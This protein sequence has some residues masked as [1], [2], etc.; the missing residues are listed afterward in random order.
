M[1]KILIG[2]NPFGRY[3]AKSLI[4]KVDEIHVYEPYYKSNVKKMRRENTGNLVDVSLNELNYIKDLAVHSNSPRIII[5]TIPDDH[6]VIMELVNILAEDDCI[7]NM[8][9][10][11]YKHVTEA[12]DTCLQ[13][14]IN[15]LDCAVFDPRNGSPPRLLVSGHQTTYSSYEHFFKEC[16]DNF[17]Y[18]DQKAGKATHVNEVYL[19]VETAMLQA[20]EDISTY[21]NHDMNFMYNVTCEL[22]KNYPI[23]NKLIAE[24]ADLY[25]TR[26]LRELKRLRLEI[27]NEGKGLVSCA[28][29]AFKSIPRAT[30]ISA[31]VANQLE[32]LDP[33]ECLKVDDNKCNVQRAC[34]A[35]LFVFC[36]ILLEADAL[37][38]VESVDVP[39]AKLSLQESVIDCDTFR[40]NNERL[41]ELTDM[42]HLSAELI[43]TKCMQNGYNIPTLSAAVQKYNKLRARSY[44]NGM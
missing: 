33:F 35:L 2:A 15:Y 12:A 6:N 36:M 41:H 1:S 7:I 5:N 14:G 27:T 38:I 39:L 32:H 25:K 34:N 40:E 22:Q 26:D 4:S 13:V 17:I 44:K 20:F 11:C 31:A 29:N 3:I 37:L 30:I 28:T 18:F 43:V 42:S 23:D 8:G 10:S 9:K 21:C 24:L 19:A 16:F